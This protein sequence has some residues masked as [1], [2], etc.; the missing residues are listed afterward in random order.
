MDKSLKTFSTDIYDMNVNISSIVLQ[1]SD[2]EIEN[3]LGNNTQ[4]DN[5][6]VELVINNLSYTT[7]Q[8]QQQSEAY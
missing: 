4:I 8:F 5:P 3:Y 6:I 7:K 2:G 1:L